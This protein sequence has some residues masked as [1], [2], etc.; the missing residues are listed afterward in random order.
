MSLVLFAA[1]VVL[2]AVGILSSP[3]MAKKVTLRTS[4]GPTGTGKDLRIQMVAEAIRRGTEGWV[5]DVINGPTTVAEITMMGRGEIDFTALDAGSI[6]DIGRGFYGGKKLPEPVAMRWLLPSTAMTCA[7]YMRADIPINSYGDILKKKYPLKFSMGRRGTDPYIINLRVLEAYGLSIKMI[8]KWGGK[9]QNTA[10]RRSADLISDGLME[11]LI[12][13]GTY[14]NPPIVQVARKRDMKVA[15]VSE[16]DTQAK[17]GER[18]FVEVPIKAGS[19][20]FVKQ[21][22]STM[23]MPAVF[24]VRED[25][26]D[27]I[28]YHVTKAVWE[29]RASFLYPIHAIFRTYLKP[30]LVKKW[31]SKFKD[32]LHPGAAKYWKEQG[33][34]N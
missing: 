8:K 15:F 17:L 19:M 23:A 7:M 9:Q 5:V 22:M 33:L 11:A 32:V 26:K 31:N 24:V 25:M 20:T 30:D 27:D 28:A 3:V 1:A 34:L 18:G 14:P 4:G 16:P 10:S 2:L 6:G 12:H 29:Q 21:D 13:A